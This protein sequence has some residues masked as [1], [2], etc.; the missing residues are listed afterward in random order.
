MI[1]KE[2]EVYLI[3]V[4]MYTFSGKKI[5]KEKQETESGIILNIMDKA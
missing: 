1:S 4:E 2:G 3:D 5:D